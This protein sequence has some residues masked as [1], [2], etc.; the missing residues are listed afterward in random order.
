MDKQVIDKAMLNEFVAQ[1]IGSTGD[2][3]LEQKFR[4]KLGAQDDA[5]AYLMKSGNSLDFQNFANRNL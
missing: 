5:A 4:E 2:K 1:Y 3:A